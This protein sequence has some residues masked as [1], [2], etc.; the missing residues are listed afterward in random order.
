MAQ[1]GR[2]RVEENYT[3]SRVAEG[4]TELIRNCT[5]DSR[6]KGADNLEM[7]IANTEK[8]YNVA[9]SGSFGQFLSSVHFLLPAAL[10]AIFTIGL[11]I[12]VTR[13]ATIWVLAENK[14]VE[15]VTFIILLAA[16]FYG[17][18]FARKLLAGGEKFVY[19]LF[20]ALFSLGLLFTGFEEIAWGQQLW[21]FATPEALTGLNM[22]GETTLHNIKGLHGKHRDA[23]A[24]V[25]N[26]RI[27][28]NPVFKD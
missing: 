18:N 5:G 28:R 16:G 1:K 7:E 9:P 11:A 25:W 22:Q 21:G 10:V 17:L 23:E 19:P 4:I 6:S 3:W 13:K 2:L 12:P 26:R 15:I 8:N 27:G 14:P 20:Y 24:A